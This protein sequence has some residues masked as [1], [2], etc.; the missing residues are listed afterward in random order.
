[1][2]IRNILKNFSLKKPTSIAL[3]TN[4][5]KLNYA[6]FYRYIKIVQN[7]IESRN[8]KS[9]IIYGEKK[10]FS[11]I[12]IFAAI[13]SNKT[14]IPISKNLPKKRIYKIIKTTKAELFI[15]CS[16]KKFQSNVKIIK[17]SN[18]FF[19]SN[20]KKCK[21]NKKRYK[22]KLAYIIFTSGSTGNPKGVCISRKALDH[23]VRWLHDD[24]LIQNG[25]SC[26]QFSEISFDLSIMDIFST[27]IRGGRLIIADNDYEKN[28][29]GKFI[30]EK[31]IDNCVFVPSMIDLLKKSGQLKHLINLKKIIFCGEPLLKSHLVSLFNINKTLQVIN[32]Y[33]P[34][35]ST[36]S[37][38]KLVLKWKNYN[39]FCIKNSVSFGKP[40]HGVNFKLVNTKSNE[41]ELLISG[42]QLFDKYFKNS[43]ETNKKKLLIN[44]KIFYRTGDCVFLN[45]KNYYFV[46]RIDK[47]V[48]INGMRI[49]LDEINN[50]LKRNCAFVYTFVEKKK[51][52]SIVKTKT[53]VVTLHKKLHLYL[54][55]YSVP[56]KIFK[57]NDLLYSPNGKIDYQKIKLQFLE[58]IK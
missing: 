19:F 8:P 44:K 23:Y 1:M 31:K 33:G 39:K 21:V 40:I 22:T 12:C 45:N 25:S 37:C 4:S 38:T 11:I 46:K 47:Q 6:N 55:K 17:I 54:P 13:F 41:S 10:L 24:V 58:N 50:Q 52:F 9:I 53:K 28:F 27:L 32:T 30:E 29:I 34:T 51:I 3:E 18:F 56:F 26:L 35:E 48:K 5:L 7:I 57:I 15:N 20:Y 2:F 14:Y 43:K 36:V 42:K 16:E 49:E